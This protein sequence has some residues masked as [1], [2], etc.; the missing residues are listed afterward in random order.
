MTYRH[1]L[2]H[3]HQLAKNQLYSPQLKLISSSPCVEE[4]VVY[5][6]PQGVICAANRGAAVLLG[7]TETDLLGIQ[8]TVPLVAGTRNEVEVDSDNQRRVLEL[9]AESSTESA[10]GW[11]R[12]SMVDVT[13]RH[14]YFEWLTFSV[15]HDSLTGLANRPHMARA[16]EEGFR[17]NPSEGFAILYVDLDHFKVINDTFGHQGGDELLRQVARR[18][19]EQCGPQDLAA[20]VGGD[21]FLI[22]IRGNRPRVRARRIAAAVKNVLRAPFLLEGQD[23]EASASVGIANYPRDGQTLDQLISSA[24]AKVYQQKD[25]RAKTLGVV[26]RHRLVSIGSEWSSRELAYDLQAGRVKVVY[27]PLVFFERDEIAVESLCRWDHSRLGTLDAEEFMEMAQRSTLILNIDEHVLKTTCQQLATW[28]K[29]QIP[30]ARASVNLSRRTMMRRDLVEFVSQA[31]H[32]TG[33]PSESLEIELPESLVL[34]GSMPKRIRALRERGIHITISRFGAGNSSIRWLQTGVADRIK[35]DPALIRNCHRSEV[36]FAILD[37][38]V[39]MAHILGI[40]V[41]ATGVENGGQ[42][43]RLRLLGC[44]GVQG[45]L[46]GKGTSP[47]VIH[48]LALKNQRS[49][50]DPERMGPG[51][52]M[53]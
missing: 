49:V 36:D 19:A 2:D 42:L 15:N 47:D 44:D 40:E 28:Q 32:E 26:E 4:A 16:I 8:L 53:M 45:F 9:Q 1:R 17:L 38:I 31:L 50:P 22:L 11:R 6:D 12:I 18:M 46:I 23:V 48:A 3:A 7:A 25:S 51:Y 29:K 20:R 24:D 10:S 5:I 39:R 52:Q 13:E 14:R 27:Q 35:V 37:A 33:I 43:E 41:V 21:E 30:V 34:D